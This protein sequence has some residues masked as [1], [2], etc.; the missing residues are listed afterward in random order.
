MAKIRVPPPPNDM[1]APPSARIVLTTSKGLITVELNGKAAPLHV[2]S[3]LY[4]SK[5][6]FF[7]GTQFHR[8]EPGFVIQGGDPLSKD[9]DTRQFAGM[10][11]PGYQIPREK[12]QL[13]HDRFVI[14]AARHQRSRFGGQPILFHARTDAIFG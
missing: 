9:A 11:G 7:D 6:G 1:K 14:A 8:Y 10:G 2:K 4:L 3:F 13:Q 12:N 5:R